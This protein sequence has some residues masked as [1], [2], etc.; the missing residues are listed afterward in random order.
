M[1]GLLYVVFVAKLLLFYG[2]PVTRDWAYGWYL[3]VYGLYLVDWLLLQATDAAMILLP[4]LFDMPLVGAYILMVALF[5]WASIR[6]AMSY[7]LLVPVLPVVTVRGVLL[8][9]K[10]GLI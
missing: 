4:L 1:P 8:V 5:D 3:A 2:L 9:I 7:T 10:F 6:L